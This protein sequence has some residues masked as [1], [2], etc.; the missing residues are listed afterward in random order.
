M[1]KKQIAQLADLAKLELSEEEMAIIEQNWKTMLQN[2]TNEQIL[3]AAEQASSLAKIDG[4]RF[5]PSFANAR[6]YDELFKK[7]RAHAFD[8]QTKQQI[9]L[10]YYVVLE[11]NYPTLFAK[12]FDMQALPQV[13]LRDLRE[14]EP[15]ESMSQEELLKNAP[16]HSAGYFV[17][18]QVVE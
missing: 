4:V 18:P 9:L 3:Q 17:V 11:E 16:N 6:S 12:A 8:T 1:T 14:D 5:A 10:G 13:A 15:K 7:T 2:L